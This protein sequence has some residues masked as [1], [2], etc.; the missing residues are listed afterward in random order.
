MTRALVTGSSGQLGLE[1]QLA[2]AAPTDCVALP[3][4]LYDRGGVGELREALAASGAGVVLHGA[5]WTAVDAAEEQ[6]EEAHRV[7][8]VRTRALA[9]ACAEAGARLVYVST[10]YVFS[11]AARAEPW[12][13]DE[14]VAPLNAYARSKRAGEEAV[15]E[16]LGDAGTVVRTSWLYGRRG[17]SFV[18]TMLRL[19]RRG[20]DLKVVDDQRGSPTWA[21]GLARALWALAAAPAAP[22]ALHYSDGGVC[23]WHDFAAEILAQAGRAGEPVGEA[24]VAPCTTAEYP[25]PAAR[26]TWSPLRWSAAWDGLGVRQRRWR[27]ALAEAL[28]HVAASELLA[29][30]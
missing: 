11:G 24:T 4:E 10:D 2:A 27:E 1:L 30:D 13:E 19:M 20:M 26:P 5:A 18:H 15:W 12:A 6:E 28:P 21:G 9:E 14:P 25:T 8:A 16:T 29:Q 7:N 17:P 23:T 3:R 22:R